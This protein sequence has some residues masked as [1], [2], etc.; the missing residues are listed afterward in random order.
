MNLSENLDAIIT[1]VFSLLLYALEKIFVNNKKQIDLSKCTIEDLV[2]PVLDDVQFE[3]KAS[4][5]AYFEL[6]NGEYTASGHS[7]KNLR[8]IEESLNENI[9]PA[10]DDFKVLPLS[11]FKRNIDKL[12]TK[13]E[14]IVSNEYL[15]HDK[16]AS[17]YNL[18][19]MNV[20]VMSKV[21][22]KNNKWTGILVVGFDDKDIK[23]DDSD[24]AFVYIKSKYL[25]SVLKQ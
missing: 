10:I 2:K 4:R 24:L 6:K 15:N 3:L 14:I 13:E 9:E 20:L 25:S 17:L 21:Y 23:L 22:T 19:N 8:M 11:V 5:V 16:E 7:L 18:Y 1:G 12:R